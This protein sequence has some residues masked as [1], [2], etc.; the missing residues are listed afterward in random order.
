MYDACV[1]IDQMNEWERERDA[2]IIIWDEWSSKFWQFL[3][4]DNYLVI[5]LVFTLLLLSLL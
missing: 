4:S 2:W 1:P 3:L 5:I